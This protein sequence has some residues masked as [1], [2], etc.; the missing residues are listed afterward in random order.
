VSFDPRQPPQY[1]PKTGAQSFVLPSGP[2]NEIFVDLSERPDQPGRIEVSVSV[3]PSSHDRIDK[4]CE[5]G[6]LHITVKMKTPLDLLTK[7]GTSLCLAMRP[8]S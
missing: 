8:V 5:F 6:K 4:R 7:W 3:D 2:T 1:P